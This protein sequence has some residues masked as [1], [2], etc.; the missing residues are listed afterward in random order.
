MFEIIRKVDFRGSSVVL[1]LRVCSRFIALIKGY[2]IFNITHLNNLA[3][4]LNMVVWSTRSRGC[5]NFW[6]SDINIVESVVP[7]LHS[8]PSTG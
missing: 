8:D 3:R 4:E 5:C 2:G 1:S 7:T 6:W